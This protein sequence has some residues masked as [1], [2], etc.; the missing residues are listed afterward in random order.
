[1]E[2]TRKRERCEVVRMR[3]GGRVCARSRRWGFENHK[4]MDGHFHRSAMT[5]TFGGTLHGLSVGR[6]VIVTE[7][8]FGAC[9]CIRSCAYALYNRDGVGAGWTSR[10]FKV[11]RCDNTVNS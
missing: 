2:S 6:Q 10:S 9:L 1:M 5:T 4:F 3:K 8:N 7:P 11:D